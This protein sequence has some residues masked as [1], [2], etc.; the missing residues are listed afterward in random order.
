VKAPPKAPTKATEK[1]KAPAKET[2]AEDPPIVISSR[3]T[4]I[5]QS[6]DPPKKAYER[7]KPRAKLKVNIQVNIFVN[8]PQIDSFV[9]TINLNDANRPLYIQVYRMAADCLRAHC[10]HIR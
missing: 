4:T 10:Q 5:K 3:P 6:P 7:P 1:A 9:H 2:P 8:Y